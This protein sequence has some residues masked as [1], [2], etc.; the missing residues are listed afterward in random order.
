MPFTE[1][2]KRAISE[3]GVF[4]PDLGS[5]GE[6]TPEGVHPEVY[7]AVTSINRSFEAAGLPHRVEHTTKAAVDKLGNVAHWFDPEAKGR[8]GVDIGQAE[9]DYLLEM[10][11]WLD[12]MRRRT[13]DA[14]ALHADS[15]PT[16][17]PG[18]EAEALALTIGR[19]VDEKDRAYG[20]AADKGP[21]YLALLCPEGIKP[22][23]YHRVPTCLFVFNKLARY[24]T[25][26]DAFGE[27][28]LADA[29]GYLILAMLRRRRAAAYGVPQVPCPPGSP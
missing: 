19:M 15:D 9:L 17:K 1:A 13:D 29:I 14:E 7:R 18:R 27:D 10:A 16:N 22:E 20:G 3:A 23:Q 4:V 25:Q 12:Y 21:A 28:P 8:G 11:G 26:P 24:M 5:P 2:G 6:A